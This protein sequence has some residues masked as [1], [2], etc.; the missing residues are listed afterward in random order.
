MSRLDAELKDI[1]KSGDGHDEKIY[2]NIMDY[3]DNNYPFQ[4]FIGCRGMGKTY[5]SLKGCYLRCSES[6]M[7][8]KFI[9]MRRTQKQLNHIT[10]GTQGEGLN[11]F[12]P[13]N[14]DMGINVG[15]KTIQK[16]VT[17]IFDRQDKDGGYTYLPGQYGYG[18]AM[19]TVAS[20]KGI[21]AS[22]CVDWIYDEF[23]K[24]KH[25][26]RMAG[27]FEAVMNAYETFCRNREFLGKP[28]LRF[29]ALSNANDIYNVLFIGLGIVND[30]E[31]MVR[32]G[33][34][35]K[36]Y[37]DR[38]L[39]I[40]IMKPSEAF[41]DMKD[42]TALSKLTKGTK[43]HDMAFG[44][45]F[46]FNDFSLIGYKNLTGYRPFCRVG[47]AYIYAKKGERSFYVCYAR[48]KCEGFNPEL[49]QDVISFRRRF[50]TQLV[51]PYADGCLTFESYE[52]KEL[53]LSLI[54]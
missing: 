49:E 38:G 52:L 5:S 10:D 33:Q 16:D 15:F 19:T 4:I 27:E 35:H 26:K 7:Q 47:N 44:N 30:A 39:A 22:D 46:A 34:Q 14:R 40:H 51:D 42:K 45:Q 25:E 17:G 9:Y 23:I 53:I 8:E 48:A 24:E 32:K 41:A 29:W 50:G 13:L 1:C 18:L 31:K 3:I 12:K 54:L 2:V 20:I 21:D 37:N 11:P 36:Y 28:P 43:F 6:G